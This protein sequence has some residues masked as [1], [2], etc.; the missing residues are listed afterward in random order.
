VQVEIRAC[1]SAQDPVIVDVN[2]AL[3]QVYVYGEMVWQGS[4]KFINSFNSPRRGGLFELVSV[5]SVEGDGLIA[6]KVSMGWLRQLANLK[7]A[8]ACSATL[9]AASQQA[10]AHL[11]KVRSHGLHV[12]HNVA[13][14]RG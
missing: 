10:A 2:K 14:L 13:V 4:I 8:A 5:L 7:G 11:L 3:Q 1:S 6:F 9:C 12:F